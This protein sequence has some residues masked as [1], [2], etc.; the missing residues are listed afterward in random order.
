MC[1]I[2]GLI[3][4]ESISNPE[5]MSSALDSMRHRGPDD[6]GHWAGRVG[7]Y[8]V[9]LLHTR[10]SI[11]DTSS[12]GHQPMR[13]EDGR[14]VIVFNGEVYNFKELRK[15]L[16]SAGVTFRGESDTEVLLATWQVWGSQ[17]LDRLEGMFAF[18]IVDRLEQSLHLVRDAFGI[19]PLF[20][21]AS[22]RRLSFASD[23]S[24]LRIVSGETFVESQRA[25]LNYLC[26][27]RY[28]LG[29]E[30]FFD[31]VMRL[32]PS[33]AIKIRLDS[34]PL[35][36]S[37]WQWW[38]PPIA[39]S[40][41]RTYGEAVEATRTLLEESVKQ[42]LRSDVP[43]GVALSGGVDSSSLVGLV[44]RVEPDLEV[45]TFSFVSPGFTRDEEYWVDRVNEALGTHANKVHVSASMMMR[46][47]DDLIRTQG[48]PFGS[49]SIFAQYCVY[50][51]ARESNVIVI[52][53]GQGADELFAGYSG[54]PASRIQSLIEQHR[55]GQLTRL[56]NSWPL[57]PGRSRSELLTALAAALMP[58]SASPWLRRQR[59]IRHLPSFIHSG[60][61]EQVLWKTP[62]SLEGVREREK[63]RSLVGRL[64]EACLDGDLQILLRHGDRN[65]MRWSVESRV[66]FLSTSI[67]ELAFSLPEEFL[68]SPSGQ[69]KRVLRDAMRGTIPSEVLYRRDKVGF[70]TPERKW[71]QELGDVRDEWLDG[72][73]GVEAVNLPDA[74]RFVRDSLSGRRPYSW[75]V[76]RLLNAGR[77]R[78]V[79]QVQ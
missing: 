20:I 36:I 55:F 65:S 68:L 67:A 17:C 5:V 63:G 56:L 29:A 26:H 43:V 32:E 1:G 53:D 72:L 7:A 62:V 24:T 70:E 50:R 51:A 54:Y 69:T 47:I 11:I 75:M 61:A 49:T 33:T 28:D 39:E 2:A 9:S 16:L 48:E 4:F 60:V 40:G 34:V 8:E 73:Q 78:Q 45:Q 44:R 41:P 13:S 3:D 77:W 23:L 37:S 14:Y 10:L 76:W 35:M 59:A 22:P 42:Q 66:P 74:R 19:K 30:T 58:H 27:G 18:A 31:D 25:M 57:Y 15:E 71:L 12:A 52:L 46:D 38:C 79:M 21:R 64:R 6:S